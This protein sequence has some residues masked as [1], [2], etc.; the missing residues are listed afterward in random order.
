[1]ATQPSV[2]RLTEPGAV[3]GEGPLWDELTQR[4]YW[5]DIESRIL[6]RCLAD[7][8]DARSWRLEQ[9]MSC[10]ALRHERPGFIAGL[11]S[12]VGL[13]TLE[14]LSIRSIAAPEATEPDNRCND[15]KCDDAGRFWVGTCD[16]AG[17]RHSGWLYRIDANHRA[18]RAAGPFICTNGPAFSPDGRTLYCVDSYARTIFAFDLAADGELSCQRVLLR[19]EDPAWGYPDGLTCDAEGCI[20]VAHWGGSRVS[21]LAPSGEHL[22]SIGL[23]VSQPS[24]CIFGGP[25]LKTL[26]I[27]SAVFG[28]DS[29]LESQAGAVFAVRL[30][31]GGM[32]TARY[33]D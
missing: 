27:T 12:S 14:P 23:P 10:V 24:S 33:R 20:W 28:L 22:S 5:L 32:P 29:A 15:G 17:R 9:P 13:V 6:H 25:D 1:M 21:R 8:S 4:L 11:Q 3:L 19:F 30:D 7:G 2:E 18:V 26:F 16:R 31:V